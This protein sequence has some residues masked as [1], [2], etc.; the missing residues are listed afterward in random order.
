MGQKNEQIREALTKLG[1][2]SNPKDIMASQ[3]FDILWQIY[4]T[5][6]DVE[7]TPISSWVYQNEN[8]EV[9]MF[10]QALKSAVDK[11]KIDEHHTTLAKSH[12]YQVLD[13]LELAG[14]QKSRFVDN[15]QEQ[16]LKQNRYMADLKA[17]VA[18]LDD[19][20]KTSEE[21]AA[22]LSEQTEQLAQKNDKMVFDFVT[23]LGIFTSI[24]FATFGG[25]QL[26]GNVFGHV[27]NYQNQA[28]GSEIMLGSVFLFGTYVILV[29]LLSGISKLIDREY[30]TTRT[31]RLF[32]VV[33]IGIIFIVGF[34]YTDFERATRVSQWLY[35]PWW[36]LLAI[37]VGIFVL[38]AIICGVDIGIKKI[39]EKLNV[40]SE[41]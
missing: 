2:I 37:T 32:V 18:E 36:H 12:L 24:T 1:S 13:I 40:V 28:I 20:L 11:T 14:I 30:Q 4:D 23:I 34:V 17:Q 9:S 22:R 7:A 38:V 16:L 41:K 3:H 5:Q 6:N 25:L 26:L 15:L 29:S 10:K 31:I 21:Q 35:Q 19:K 8:Y 39:L 27:K 33:S